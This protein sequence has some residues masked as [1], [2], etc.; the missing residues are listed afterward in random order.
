MKYSSEEF[1]K[2]FNNREKNLIDILLNDDINEIITIENNSNL[3]IL[4]CGINKGK[5]Y[6]R[7]ND[8]FHIY[9]ERSQMEIIRGR[10][11]ET[12]IYEDKYYD[13]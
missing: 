5:N 7:N 2:R 9:S 3:F 13:C 10:M 8:L 4:I 6:N 12:Y 11:K 1:L